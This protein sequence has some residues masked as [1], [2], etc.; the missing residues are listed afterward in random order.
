FFLLLLFFVLFFFLTASSSF[1]SSIIACLIV[2][3]FY[4][5]TGIFN[6][7]MLTLVKVPYCS[8]SP[9]VTVLRLKALLF[10]SVYFVLQTNAIPIGN[11]GLEEVN[12]QDQKLNSTD[13]LREQILFYLRRLKS[14]LQEAEV[15]PID[16]LNIDMS[17]FTTDKDKLFLNVTVS[18]VTI[19]GLSTIDISNINL[20]QEDGKVEVFG[21]IALISVDTDLSS[22]GGIL[23][24][25]LH[26]QGHLKLNLYDVSTALML[27]YSD[28]NRMVHVIKFMSDFTPSKIVA[29]F[30]GTIDEDDKLGQGVNTFLNENSYE[31]YNDSKF[32]I[33]GSLD[34]MFT[35]IINNALFYHYVRKEQNSLYEGRR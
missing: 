2:F 3:N 13:C 28:K 17:S 6:E 35:E 26:G 21:K 10:I 7:K 25:P 34:K 14:G 12:C 5:V 29:K 9:L 1:L 18:N 11:Y 27:Y 32:L 33:L 23:D 19:R 15:P 16:P 4:F 22:E 20:N 30:S 24:F 31:I 8:I